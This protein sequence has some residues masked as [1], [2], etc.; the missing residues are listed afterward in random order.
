MFYIYFKE[1]F[2]AP[3][4]YANEPKFQ[5]LHIGL[6]DFEVSISLQRVL[7]R[8]NKPHT[9]DFKTCVGSK[10]KKRTARETLC[11]QLLTFLRDE[12]N[13]LKNDVEGKKGEFYK[14]RGG[15][16][17]F[18]IL[19]GIESILLTQ[20]VITLY[21]QFRK[22]LEWNENGLNLLKNRQKPMFCQKL[23]SSTTNNFFK[24]FFCQINSFV[25]ILKKSTTI[26]YI[27]MWKT[28]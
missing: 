21:V 5:Y 1:R 16:K 8:R 3:W 15:K 14:Q 22:K 13:I 20:V 27:C 4:L 28:K 26:F 7:L 9:I 12:V 24:T 18:F 25:Y 11:E 6:G 17:K 2:F 10:N 19:C 23:K